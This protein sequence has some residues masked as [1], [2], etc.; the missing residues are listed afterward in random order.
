MSYATRPSVSGLVSFAPLSPA[1]LAVQGCGVLSA[2]KIIGETAGVQPFHSKD[3]FAKHNGTAPLPVWSANCLRHPRAPRLHPGVPQDLVD[4]ATAGA[5]LASERAV[6][7]A[8]GPAWRDGQ[9]GGNADLDRVRV[10]HR[11]PTPLQRIIKA[12]DASFGESGSPLE[13]R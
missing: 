9:S 13:H 2:A 7:P 4:F 10:V 5:E 8:T 12:V 11:W 6:A 1:L 3:A